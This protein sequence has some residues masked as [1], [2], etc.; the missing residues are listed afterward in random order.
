MEPMLLAIVLLV[1]TAHAPDSLAAKPKPLRTIV[2]SE[3]K[4][5]GVELPGT[6]LPATDERPFEALRVE[7]NTGRARTITVATLDPPG[8]TADRWMFSGQVHYENV[9]GKGYLELLNVLA[10]GET[11]YSRTL[12]RT[13]PSAYLTGDS[14][15]RPFALVFKRWK[16]G[17]R[18]TRIL[19]NVV[20]PESGV[21]DLSPIDVFEGFDAWPAAD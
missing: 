1:A 11:Y 12:S 14:G 9:L 8:I 17:N 18:P 16:K 21:V 5:Q 2:W 6:I 3:L 19:V 4:A 20:L 15:W 7:N 10:D 13:G